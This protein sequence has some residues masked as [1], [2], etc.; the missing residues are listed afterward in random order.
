MCTQYI[1]IYIVSIYMIYNT[2]YAIYIYIYILLYPHGAG[3]VGIP[4]QEVLPRLPVAKKGA[5]A[6]SHS[7][8]SATHTFNYQN[9]DVLASP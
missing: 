4:G 6:R 9:P 7:K 5:C 2:L 1:Y 3:Y 8:N